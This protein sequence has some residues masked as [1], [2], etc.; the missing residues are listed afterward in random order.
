MSAIPPSIRKFLDSGRGEIRQLE[1]EYH[2]WLIATSLTIFTT[3]L[4]ITA[5]TLL[6]TLESNENLTIIRIFIGLAVIGNITVFYFIYQEMAS[7][8]RYLL[9]IQK[10][11]KN[12]LSFLD[13]IRRGFK[14]M[15]GG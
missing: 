11:M 8:R 5:L 12:G 4:M 3:I 1:H 13:S 10:L 6:F 9:E 2:I 14:D 15:F 7:R